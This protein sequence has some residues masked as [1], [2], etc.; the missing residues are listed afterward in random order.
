VEKKPRL[1]VQTLLKVSPIFPQTSTG[2]SKN[3]Y[4]DF[5]GYI[6]L[7]ILIVESELEGENL[8]I[9]LKELF[10]L[11]CTIVYESK[12]E[13]GFLFLMLMSTVLFE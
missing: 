9:S 8:P 6:V 13:S 3:K 2:K 5:V 1:R 4:F 11:S 7:L 12:C 10:G